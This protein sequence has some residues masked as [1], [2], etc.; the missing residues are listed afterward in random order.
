[1]IDDI[2]PPRNADSKINTPKPPD[3][4]NDVVPEP[5]F[6][7]P[8]EISG[9]EDSLLRDNTGSIGLGSSEPKD[10]PDTDSWKSRFLSRGLKLWPTTKKQKIIGAAIAAVL[11]VSG[12]GGVY[13]L[14]KHFNT[15]KP[16]AAAP[17]V[18]KVV[19]PPKT[20]EASRLTGVEIPIETNKRPVTAIMIE[21]SPDARPQSGLTEAGIVFEA[22]AEGG[23]TR[24][25]ALFL[26]T[27]PDY[28]GPVRSVR[29]Y[30]IDLFLPFDAAIVH[31]GGSAEGLAKLRDLGVKDLDHGA[32]GGAFK[33]VSDRFA[34]HNL[35]TSMAELDK[36]SQ[37]RGYITS[38]F[39][40]F[41]RKAD[42]P[43][44]TPSPAR[45]IDF[46]M[47]GFLY[48]PHFEYDAP[49][50]RYVRS[51]AGKLHTDQRSGAPIQP[52]AVIAL[53]MAYG[54]NGIYSVYQTTGQGPMFVFQDGEVVPGTWK[55]AGPKDQFEFI[56]A[57]GKKIALNPGQTWI[58]LVKDAGAVKY[59]P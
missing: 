33:R 23:I 39:T 45:I 44:A 34:P 12:G 1:M 57:A 30:Y 6:V 20:T 38:T 48:N 13:A 4:T 16:Q 9:A 15:S 14:N 42:K 51:M 35:Y 27:Q 17:V 43:I 26:E 47:S 52:K 31:A 50:N 8:E 18:E 22:I 21:N 55:K 3:E 7:R 56:D 46:E 49:N 53:V 54:Q 11:I 40:S 28:I 2:R 37:G 29:P 58:T 24:F 59:A 41:L 36:A 5:P 10:I 19:E 32:N 25:N